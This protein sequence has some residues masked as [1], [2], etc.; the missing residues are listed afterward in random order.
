MD[1]VNANRDMFV[2]QMIFAGKIANNMATIGLDNANACQDII[3]QKHGIN[4]K[5]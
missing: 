1:N 5:K 2:Q 4:V 3:G